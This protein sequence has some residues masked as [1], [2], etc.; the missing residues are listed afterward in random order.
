MEI[1]EETRKVFVPI[2]VGEDIKITFNARKGHRTADEYIK[3]LMELEK[4]K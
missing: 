1:K 2:L 4:Q 3:H